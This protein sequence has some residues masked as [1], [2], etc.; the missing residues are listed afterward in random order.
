M[1]ILLLCSGMIDI[2]DVSS[3]FSDTCASFVL[4]AMV[5]LQENVQT[6]STTIAAKSTQYD[7]TAKNAE[8]TAAA[9]V[10]A[11]AR[12]RIFNYRVLSHLADPEVSARMHKLRSAFRSIS[13]EVLN[14]EMKPEQVFLNPAVLACFKKTLTFGTGAGAKA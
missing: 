9:F 12:V 6:M 2:K 10:L 7:I 8:V 5:E 14:T 1:P 4:S 3:V 13:V 11:E